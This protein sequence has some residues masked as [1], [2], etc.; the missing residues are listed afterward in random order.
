MAHDFEARVVAKLDTSE[1][2]RELNNLQNKKTEVKFNLNSGNASKDIDKINS[3]IKAAR[4]NTQTFGQTLK[5]ALN[6]GSA[7]A[8]TSQGIRL[9]RQAAN[10]A[11]EA[12]KDFDAA[13]T[14]IR[15]VTGNS[16]SA[17]SGMVKQYNQVG[18][19]LGSTT[20]EVSNSAVTWL[21]QGKTAQEANSLI[22]KSMMLSKISFID[23]ADAA[24]YLTSALNGYKI[25]VDGAAGVLD[26]VAKLD[27][28]AAVTAGG[29]AEG[30]SR[31]AVTANNMG[32][33]M[34]RLLGYLTA[35][36]NVNPNLDMSS[37]GNSLKTMFTRMSNIKAGKLELIDEDG[38][39]EIL[40]DVETVLN[41]AGI[42]LRDSQNEF[43]NFGEVLD[44]VGAAW[45][46]YSSVQQA[47]IAK[48]FAGTRQQ[49][50]F[51]VLMDNYQSAID[52]ANLA[53]DSAGTA[54]QKFAAYL[55]SIEAKSKSLQAAFESLATNTVSTESYA[56]I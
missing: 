48:A 45:D 5:N 33:S 28:A 15:T 6:I 13:I 53:A 18:Q 26:K 52:F 46:T 35:I 38:T 16:Y 31:T 4:T 22:Y 47:A 11:T 40:S 20:K 44:E 1:L 43:R 56:G 34:D 25:A 17:A 29:L 7:A 37:I 14:D 10:E 41:N 12:I 32:I 50:N 19:A 39:V 24:T 55:D 54:E 9:V 27:S 21:R 42:K 51:R 23:S 3:S 36:G 2:E 30:M 8:V 49:E